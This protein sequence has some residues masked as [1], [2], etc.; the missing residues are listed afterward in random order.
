MT[1]SCREIL[2]GSILVDMSPTLLLEVSRKLL[3]EP[4]VSVDGPLGDANPGLGVGATVGEVGDE[5]ATAVPP[6]LI[7]ESIVE[8]E[9]Q[10]VRNNTHINPTGKT[11]WNWHF[12]NG[13]KSRQKK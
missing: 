7:I 8:P 5:G 11:I 2:G 13:K 4:M 1:K 9:S 6:L 10:P 3:L 12:R